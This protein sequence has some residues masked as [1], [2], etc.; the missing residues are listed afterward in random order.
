[1]CVHTSP[2][3]TSPHLNLSLDGSRI[4][5]RQSVTNLLDEYSPFVLLFIGAR[6]RQLMDSH[7]PA[8]QHSVAM[9]KG[10]SPCEQP[11]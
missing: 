8:G 1:V 11:L 3:P 2:W 4:L 10:E 9:L 5:E 7:D 6:L